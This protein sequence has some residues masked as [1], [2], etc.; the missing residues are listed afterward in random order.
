MTDNPDSFDDLEADLEA[1]ATEPDLLIIGT[2]I[3]VYSQSARRW[4]NVSMGQFVPDI[5]VINE[6]RRHVAATF[7]ILDNLT[8]QLYRG[9][10]TLGQWQIAVAS[11]LKDAHLAQSMFAVG[12]KQ[13]MSAVEFGRVGGTLA[14][15]YRHLSQFADDIAAGRV[16]AAQAQARIQQY[17]KAAQQ[18]F[19]REYS[20]TRPGLINWVLH[21]AD[22]C[23]DCVDLAAGSPYTAATL[24]THPGAG[25]T[26]CRGNCN[27]TLEDVA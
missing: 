3:Y 17:G 2:G 7:D 24:P 27:C 9:Q 23:P 11:E 25:E 5:T 15:E 8:S 20:L 12:G 14:D 26:V 10:I 4:V 13:N 1:D 19:W 22:H 18:S 21:P 6:M 16:S